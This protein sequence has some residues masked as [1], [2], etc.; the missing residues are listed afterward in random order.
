MLGFSLAVHTP[1]AWHL[2]GASGLPDEAP[3][4]IDLYLRT[5]VD[6]AC[7]SDDEDGCDAGISMEGVDEEDPRSCR[8]GLQGVSP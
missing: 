1:E 6:E 4:P 8:H 7:G 5:K 3:P 2:T